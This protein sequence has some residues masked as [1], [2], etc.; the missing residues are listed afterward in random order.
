MQFGSTFLFVTLALVGSS[1]AQDNGLPATGVLDLVS[2][3]VATCQLSSALS[4]NVK[5]LLESVRCSSYS[6][7]RLVGGRSHRAVIHEDY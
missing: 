4:L 2:I 6:M 5:C 1:T 7:Y 3:T